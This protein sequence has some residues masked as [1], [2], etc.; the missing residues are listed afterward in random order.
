MLLQL[1]SWTQKGTCAAVPFAFLS[2]AAAGGRAGRQA[3]FPL[4]PVAS[5][6]TF[7]FD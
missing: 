6:G 4:K 7:T 1:W 2:L 5:L 3:R